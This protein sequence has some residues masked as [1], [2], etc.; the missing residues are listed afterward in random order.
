MMNIDQP[1][2][3]YILDLRKPGS[4][5]VSQLD[6]NLHWTIHWEVTQQ[7]SSYFIAV[8]DPIPL[9][10]TPTRPPKRDPFACVLLNFV[11]VLSNVAF[12]PTTSDF[13]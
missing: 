13:D 5:K 2:M 12:A 10:C 6:S 1:W 11:I 9:G 8:G 7:G 3:R 4:L